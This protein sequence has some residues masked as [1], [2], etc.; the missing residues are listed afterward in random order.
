MNTT[1]PVWVGTAAWRLMSRRSTSV[2]SASLIEAPGVVSE[3]VLCEHRH[4]KTRLARECGERMAAERNV[5]LAQELD[6]L[7]AMAAGNFA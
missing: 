7:D 3:S 6:D 4:R 1:Y 5:R 2:G